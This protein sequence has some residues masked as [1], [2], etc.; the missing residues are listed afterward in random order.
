MSKINSITAYEILDSRGNPTIETEVSLVSGEKASACVPSGASTGSLE[1]LE[2]RDSDPNRYNGKGVLKAVQHVNTIIR[3]SL[4]GKEVDDQRSLD[5]FMIQL[6]GSPNKA[7]LGANAILSV[8]LAIAKAAALNRKQALYE[9]FAGLLGDKQDEKC[10]MP[11]PMMNIINGGAHA[12]NNLDI[13]EFMVL[14]LGASSFREALRMGV[15]IFHALKSTLKQKGLNTNVGDEGGFAPNLRSH[16]EALD[17]IL[18]AIGKVGCKAGKDVYLG[19]DAASTEFYHEGKY[20]IEAKRL[21]HEEWIAYLENLVKQ[22]PIISIEDGMAEAD[23]AGWIALTQR[24][25][26]KVQL[27]GDDLFVTNPALFQQGIDKKLANAILITLEAISL[28]KKANYAAIISHRSGETE[29]T[30]IADLTVGT[31]V[32]QIKTGSACRT[33]RIAK[34]NRLLRIEA[35]QE[36]HTRYAGCQIFSHFLNAK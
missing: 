34:Y 35:D 14:P 10:I 33:D 36:P 12:D 23:E 8:S 17:C 20:C 3:E 30:T 9:Y 31:G 7:N 29:D 21:N 6:D 22:Y 15:E 1:A 24:L 4:V 32:G 19:L 5:A 13:Q 11:V 16:D 28:A 26:D 2:L 18:T 27:V 25:G